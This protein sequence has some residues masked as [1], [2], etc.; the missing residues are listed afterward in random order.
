M[1]LMEYNKDPEPTGEIAEAAMLSQEFSRKFFLK[2][3]LL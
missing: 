2:K 3:R 1:G